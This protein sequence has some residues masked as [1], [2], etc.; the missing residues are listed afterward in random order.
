[1]NHPTCIISQDKLILDNLMDFYKSSSNMGK[2]LSI[3]KGNSNISLRIVDWFVTNYAKQYYTIITNFTDNRFKVYLS[4]KQKLKAYSKKRFDPFCR[5]DRITLPYGPIEDNT[6][7][8]TTIGQLNFFKWALENGIIS[9][10]EDHYHDIELDMIRR[11]SISKKNTSQ[12]QDQPKTRKKRE[13]LSISAIKTI[14]K[15][16]VEIVLKFN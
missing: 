14:K 6:E 9:Y 8:E 1:M 15:E 4:Y 7:I 10:I 16:Q 5:W 3:I 11:N 13:E 2:M 12:Y